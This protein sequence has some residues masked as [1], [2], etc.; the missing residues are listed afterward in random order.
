MSPDVRF[1]PLTADRSPRSKVAEPD[2]KGPGEFSKGDQ[3]VR[4]GPG[5]TN[6]PGCKEATATRQPQAFRSASFKSRSQYASY[7]S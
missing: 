2:P 3:W 1:A 5:P 7:S 4:K 6:G